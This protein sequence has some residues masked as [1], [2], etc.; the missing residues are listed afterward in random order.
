[1]ITG[2]IGNYKDKKQQKPLKRGTTFSSRGEKKLKKHGV[3]A[4]MELKMDALL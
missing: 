2:A 3:F 1:M 4:E